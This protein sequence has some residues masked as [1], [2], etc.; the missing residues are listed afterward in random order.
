M[1]EM[2]ELTELTDLSDPS[3]PSDPKEPRSRR[4]R[5]R[6]ATVA[7]ITATA[8]SLLVEEGAEALTLRAIARRMGLTAPAL[9]RYYDS[10]EALV[11]GLVQHLLAELI[12]QLEAARDSVARTD[13]YGRLAATCRA[14][15]RWALAHP[16]EFQLGFATPSAGPAPAN[17]PPEEVP[18]AATT[19]ADLSFGGV[20]LG[21]FEEIWEIAPFPVPDG[22][23][24]DPDLTR[25]LSRLHG[26]V[27]GVLPIGA[28]H[29]YLAGWVRLYGAVTIEVFG[30]LDFA[31][32]DAESMF[33]SMLRAMGRDLGAWEPAAPVGG[34]SA[35]LS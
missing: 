28:L 25:Q 13:P 29:A 23:E 35:Q 32:D 20:F 10:H 7:E 1:A 34:G 16:R 12:G 11:A 22:S 21:I 3:D 6:D 27:G 18:A 2:S 5:A 31:F 17:C 26:A 4:A 33:E 15:R 8:R 30:H 24:L 14:F 19:P 9:Y